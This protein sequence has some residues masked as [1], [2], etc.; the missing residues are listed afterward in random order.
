MCSYNATILPCL[1]GCI[2]SRECAAKLEH[3]K[4]KGKE[5]LHIKSTS[6]DIAGSLY[7]CI[8]VLTCP[9]FKCCQF[10]HQNCQWLKAISI[11]VNWISHLGKATLR[12][13]ITKTQ[14]PNILG[15]HDQRLVTRQQFG[16]VTWP[17]NMKSSVW[18]SPDRLD[19]DT[20]A[21]PG[22]IQQQ[23]DICQ[24]IS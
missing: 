1:R 7:L 4:W 22:K 24:K 2:A 23:L 5:T 13:K 16:T 20:Y 14:T 12:R 19:K 9:A 21:I 15:N 17:K 3:Q 10:F 11:S 8:I 18:S 6:G